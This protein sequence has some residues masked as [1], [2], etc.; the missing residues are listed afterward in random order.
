MRASPLES[1]RAVLR[2]TTPD[3]FEDLARLRSTPEVSR[4]W[5]AGTPVEV[6]H[7]WL[8]GIDDGDAHWTIWVDDV[9]RGFVQAYEE[10][11][12]D[13]RH[14]GIDLFLDPEVHGRGHG[15]EVVARVARHLFEDV[16]H[17]RVVIDPTAA[18]EPA[19]RCYE[20]VGFRRVGVMRE[21]WWDHVEQR[22]A[23]G[24]LLDLLPGDLR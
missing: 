24:L 9:R 23:D 11:D 19:V 3:D 6:E 7:E 14:A 4:W 22:W 21:Y 17:H 5:P 13:Y 20:A 15:R 1:D 10:T 18:N 16:G 12:P 2:P 8:Q